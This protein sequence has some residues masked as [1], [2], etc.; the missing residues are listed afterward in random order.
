MRLNELVKIQAKGKK[1]VGR[2][3]GSGLGKTAGRGTKGQKARGKIPAA[4]AGDLSLYKKLPRKRGMGNS[5]V[6]IKP[7]LLSLSRLS[8]FRK[9]TIVDTNA[10]IEAGIISQKDAKTGVKILGTGEI[11]QALVIKLSTSKSARQKIEKMG[12]TVE[13]V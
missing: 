10:L 11:S 12:G 4:F 9:K 2:G 7:K 8:G 3:V 5:K 13:N 6:T 1:R